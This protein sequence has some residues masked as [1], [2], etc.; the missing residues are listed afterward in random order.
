MSRC[1]VRDISMKKLV[2]YQGKNYKIEDEDDL[3]FLVHFLTKEGFSVNQ[4]AYLLGIS[5]RKV[6][7]ILEDCWG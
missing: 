6:Q 5:T 7:E 1:L 4:I 2:K 3:V